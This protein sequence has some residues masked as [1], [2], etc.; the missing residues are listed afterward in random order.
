M[1]PPLNPPL[2]LDVQNIETVSSRKVEQSVHAF[3]NEYRA[4]DGDT[5]VAAQMEKFVKALAEENRARKR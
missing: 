3:L 1:D 2:R 4:R 5:A